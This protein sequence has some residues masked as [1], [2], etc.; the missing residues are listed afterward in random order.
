MHW[1]RVKLRK[2]RSADS[3]AQG[4]APLPAAQRI[5]NAG[6]TAGLTHGLVAAPN[7]W[8]GAGEIADLGREREAYRARENGDGKE[9]D[10]EPDL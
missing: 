2:R 7:G 4:G 3:G 9:N 1:R 10:A 5:W 6:G 8:R